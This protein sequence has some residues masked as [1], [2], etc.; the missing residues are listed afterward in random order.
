MPPTNPTYSLSAVRALTLHAQNLTQPQA[1]GPPPSPQ[2]I[3]ELAE[4]L[5]C[6]QIDT[7]HM[8][9]R[10]HYLVI[11][12]RLGAYD[13]A[14]FDR[15]IYA[16]ESRRLFEYWRHAASI[17][18]LKE[19]RYQ[20]PLM[21]WY[22]QGGKGSWAEW[23]AEPVNREVHARVMDRIRH[24]GGLRSADF[25]YDGPRRGSWWDWKPAK[26]ALE[27]AFACGDLMVADRLNFQRV[28]DLKKRVLPEWVDTDNPGE[29]AARR[30]LVEEAVRALGVCLPIQAAE[31]AYLKR[32]T[33][34]V[35]VKELIESGVLVTVQ[36]ECADREVHTL[37]VHRDN[38]PLLQ[39]AAEG[40]I[41]PARTT[42][43]SPF[44]NLFWARDRDM[45]LWNFRQAL[46]AYKPARDR[47][48]GYFCLPILHNDRLIGRF[49]PKLE[50][51]EGRLRLKAL[52]LEEGV[53]P[54]EA[55]ITGVAEAFHDFLRFHEADDLVIEHSEPLEFGETL[56]AAL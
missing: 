55:L 18:P 47:I 16:P 52:Y 5:G 24:E 39:Q 30:H 2:A 25:K 45:L 31:Y 13:P 17:I 20:M 27:Y 7:L 21:A 43:L 11:W 51:K 10:S 8:V 1:A 41:V 12:S 40:E 35:F 29:E 50:R 9:Q 28:Y 19:Y 38:L 15:A 33:A 53:Q 22:Q 32:G 3:V 49:D 54:D 34:Q 56:R 44:D 36:G 14:D 4:R 42:F 26:R 48:W 37:A 6:V 46:E 23:L